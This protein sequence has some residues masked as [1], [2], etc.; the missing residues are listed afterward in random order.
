MNPAP[1]ILNASGKP[2][3]AADPVCPKGCK[4]E[5]IKTANTFGEPY[6]HCTSCGYDFRE[7][8]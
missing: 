7:A 5:F 1:V 8:T 6:K 2:V 3:K 4:P